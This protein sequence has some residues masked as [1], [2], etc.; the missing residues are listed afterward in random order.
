MTEKYI[1]HNGSSVIDIALIRGPLRGSISPLWNYDA[2]PVRKHI[3]MKITLDTEQDM[4]LTRAPQKIVRKINADKIKEET[5][6]IQQVEKL[7][8]QE[9]LEGATTALN[10]L[11]QNATEYNKGNGRRA[12]GWFDAECY[13][14]RNLVL[15]YLH[16]I[17]KN[18]F[19]TSR[20][21]R[22]AIE[23]SS[24]KSMIKRKKAEYWEAENKREAEEAQKDPYIALRLRTRHH[25][26]YMDMQ[27]WE[28]HFNSILNKNNTRS[29][30]DANDNT[31][32][33]L[34][35]DEITPF[36]T[37]EVQ[38]AI[39]ELKNKKA[40]GPDQIYNEHIKATAS[41][42]LPTWTNLYNKCLEIGRIP[43]QW[44]HSTIKVLYKGK[45]DPKDVNKYRGIAL[46]NG[47]FKT[48]AKLI[49]NRIKQ[50]I[51][52][53]LPETQFGFRS[54]RS[55]LMAVQIMLKDISQAL[56]NKAKFY[57]L[58]IDFTKAF[59]LIKRELIIQKLEETMGTRSEWTRIIKSILQYNIL[60]ISDNLTI[61]EPIIQTNGVLQGDPLSPTLF[62]L[63]AEEILRTTQKMDGV[64]T[65]AYA[66]DIAIGSDD[67]HKLQEAAQKIEK[68]CHSNGFSINVN[69]T[70]L[71]V[72]RNGGKIPAST[73]ITIEEQPVRITTDFKYLGITFQTSGR[74]FTKHITDRAIQAVI[75][76]N[77]IKNIQL[78]SLQTAMLLFRSKITPILTYGIEV[79]WEHLSEKNLATMEKVKATYLKRA[80]GVAKT[81]KSRLVYLLAREP[82]LIEEL[83]T[84]YPLPS[85]QAYE[86]LKKSLEERRNDVWPEFYA[87]GAMIDRAWM[88]PNFELRH[89]LTRLAVHGFHHTMCK[90]KSYHVPVIECVCEQ[91]EERCERYHIEVCKN[92]KRSLS[93]YAKETE[94]G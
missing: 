42:L 24:Y 26:P 40:A 68:W 29:P 64:R 52:E 84:Q 1:C 15:Q 6:K 25:R 48:L 71:M 70:E 44:R 47:P 88:A 94:R 80:I 8:E 43:E 53:I 90:V 55:T 31:Q 41:T 77:D 85:T 45:G 4:P 67:L 7:I 74:C 51:D 78:L 89:V 10:E 9:D 54:G 28:K 13:L 56:E 23:R 11:L 63:T 5:H 59:D 61:S 72:F 58:F 66:D 14:K 37:T 46:E 86:K 17:R 83:R 57:V 79:I 3:P 12:Q 19:D 75:A 93:S 69:K 21:G 33:K 65:Y 73:K 62:I 81:T 36:T 2:T 38:K 20:K 22:Y 39:N 60:R 49:N 35:K 30:P 82:F 32:I 92:S 76:I 91:C 18:P 50:P 16:E 34:Q 27:E 87:T